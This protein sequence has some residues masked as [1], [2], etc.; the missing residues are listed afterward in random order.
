MLCVAVIKGSHEYPPPPGIKPSVEM[1]T[2]K[3][4][5]PGTGKKGGR[6]GG[7]ITAAFGGASGQQN[8]YQSK[9]TYETFRKP[10]GGTNAT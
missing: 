4:A 1:G 7:V 8:K 9:L 6:G 3:E 10:E 2:K 5:D